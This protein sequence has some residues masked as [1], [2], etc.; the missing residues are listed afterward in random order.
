[1]PIVRIPLAPIYFSFLNLTKVDKAH[2]R[3]IE[4]TREIWINIPRFSANTA[5]RETFT[6]AQREAADIKSYKTLF[7][8]LP[9]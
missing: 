8:H 9:R 7:V 3:K 1:M 2:L 4:K 6:F 5:I